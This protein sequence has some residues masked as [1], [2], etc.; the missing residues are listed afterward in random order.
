MKI[1]SL[2]VVIGL[3]FGLFACSRTSGVLKEAQPA[4]SQNTNLKTAPTTQSNDGLIHLWMRGVDNTNFIAGGGTLIHVDLVR[5]GNVKSDTTG[6]ATKLVPIFDASWNGPE[7]FADL[8]SMGSG[9]ML[10]L[11]DGQVNPPPGTYDFAVATVEPGT[12]WIMTKDST[13]YA[14]KFPGNKFMLAFKPPVTITTMV[15]LDVVL[16]IDINRSFVKTGNSYIFKPVVQ[17][18][19]ATTAGSLT[20]FVVDA[21]TQQSIGYAV[22]TI[23]IDGTPYT[24]YTLAQPYTDPNTGVT[25]YPG[26]YYI[27]GIPA[28]TYTVS[29]E[30]DG[31]APA[32]AQV[33]IMKGNFTEQ[34][35]ALEP[36]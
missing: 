6:E 30:K 31:Y 18:V 29:V 14:V 4:S 7:Y 15:S 11:S 16:N 36:Q 1:K 25:L 23:D 22:V 12:G 24:T 2:F 34:D 5:K 21:Q 32:N 10:D 33:T 13:K 28:G 3:A 20:G 17:V 27:P 26:Q 35:F 8:L 9:I 19:N